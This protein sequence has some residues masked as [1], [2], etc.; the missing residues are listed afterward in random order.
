MTQNATAP[1]VLDSVKAYLARDHQLWID[2]KWVPSASGETF[3]VEDPATE[4]QIA[5][6]ARGGAEDIDRA[7]KVARRTHSDGGW[8]RMNPSKRGRILWKLADLIEEHTEELAQLESLDNGKPLGVARV[9]DVA[10]TVDHFRYYAGWAN[11]IEGETIPISGRG[12]RPSTWTT[13]CASRWAWSARSSPGT[14]PC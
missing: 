9:A 13:P 4:D 6:V 12:R 8:R 3:S 11:K 7:V 2:G 1:A 14:S 5:R 10:L